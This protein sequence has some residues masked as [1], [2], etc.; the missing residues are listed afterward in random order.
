MT[1]ERIEEPRDNEEVGEEKT[2]LPAKIPLTADEQGILPIIPRNTEEAGRYASA[3]IRANMVPDSYRYTAKDVTKEHQRGNE[4]REGEPNAPL[5]LAGILKGLEVGLA[6][7]TALGTIYPINGKFTVYG[8]GAVALIQRD[9]VI[10]SQE[11]QRIGVGFDHSLPPG[12]W[13]DNYGWLVR[14]NRRHQEEPYEATFTVR[15]AK[16]ANLWMNAS[17]KPWI[18]Y[19][20]R[21]LFNRARAFALRD[22][23]ADCLMGLGIR[24]EVED[25]HVAGAEEPLDGGTRHLSALDDEPETEATDREPIPTGEEDHEGGRP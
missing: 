25:W 14:F 6:P 23:F 9:R 7:Q 3:L 4:V 15:D 22:G 18:H 19:P 16:R 24:E 20:D 2:Q 17:K 21:M 1:E 10:T 12:E 5:I 11:A 8:D 13:P